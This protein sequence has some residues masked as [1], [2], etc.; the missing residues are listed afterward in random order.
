MIKILQMDIPKERVVPCPELESGTVA[1]RI[2]HEDF[3]EK[4]SK[5]DPFPPDE[6]LDANKAS[7][8]KLI[9]E[10]RKT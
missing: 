8:R 10:P 9:E 2:C 6:L 7:S 4:V 5:V 3:P 1:V